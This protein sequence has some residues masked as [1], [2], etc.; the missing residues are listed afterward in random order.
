MKEEAPRSAGVAGPR[1]VFAACIRLYPSSFRSEFGPDMVETFSQKLATLDR[2]PGGKALFLIRECIAAGMGGLSL[3]VRGGLRIGHRRKRSDRPPRLRPERTSRRLQ[4]L[5]PDLGQ[6]FR[7]ALRTL[8]RRPGVTASGVLAL[9]LGIGLTTLMMCVLYGAAFRPLPVPD[10]QRI[11]HLE[12]EDRERGIQSQPVSLHDLADWTARQSSFEDLGGFYTG[13]F[14][15]TGG[16][17]PERL[18][19]GWVTTNT[20]EILRAAP[21]AGRGFLTGDGIPGAPLVVVISQQ[22]WAARF[23]GEEDVIGR[24][25]RVNGEVATVVGIMPEGMGFPYWQ[26]AWIPIREDLLTMARGEGPNV[27]VFGRLRDGLSLEQARAQF[28]DISDQLAR[29]FPETN[30]GLQAVLE[31]Y[32]RS[33]LRPEAGAGALLLFLAVLGV[34]AIAC[35]NVANLLLAQAVARIRDL[36]I[37]VAVGAGRRRVVSMVLQ[38]A[39]IL[40]AMGAVLG[41]GLAVLGVETIDRQ[42]LA[43]A[44]F[45]PPFWMDFRVDGP[46]LLFVIGITGLSALASGVL[47]ALRASRT[48]PHALLQDD[49]R[50]G[51]SIRMGRLS[52]FL[53]TAELV[54][55]A[56]LLVA[57][58]HMVMDVAQAQEAQYSYPVDDVLTAR[59]GLF[60]G[61]FPTLDSRLEFFQRLQRGLEESPGILGAGLTSTLPGVE[62]RRS[63]FSLQSQEYGG[64]QELPRARFA[65]VSPGFFHALEVPVLSGRE[66]TVEDDADTEL[67]ALVNQSFVERYFQGVEPLGQQVRAGGMED[68]GSWLTVVGVVPDLNMDGALEPAGAPEGIY[69]P[70]AQGDLRFVNLAIRTQGDPSAFVSRLRREVMA[71]QGDTPIFFART[72]RGAINTN[73]LDYIL[74]SGLVLAF[75]LSAFLMASVGLYAVTSF[76]AAQRIRELGL[77]LALGADPGD[78]VGLVFKRGLRQ[79][80]LGLTLGVALAAVVRQISG[81]VGLE[82]SPWSIPVTLTVCLTLGGTGLWAVLTPARRAAQVDPMKVLREE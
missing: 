43:T 29:D 61:F 60:D 58:G 76:L 77:R 26:D 57:S 73:L 3:R 46:I 55:S 20:F 21:L 41:T 44:T 78:L 4:D 47:P 7:Q 81:G 23:G 16:D 30:E 33:Y 6:D 15:L 51:V 31:L 62:A 67:V 53:V 65:G 71:L 52:R 72:L 2:G 28:R 8:G 12:Q 13:S 5:V 59:V 27:E 39:L 24:T 49:H 10:G 68:D 64:E 48:D 66:F 42:L 22:V 54:V 70:L 37:R 80:L 79:V 63:T 45:P 56:A 35:F 75:G 82:V 25:V 32:T 40:S 74:I 34:L 38:E 1:R 14:Y 19:G 69:W 11:I 36:A 9:G 17:R 50:S 18:F